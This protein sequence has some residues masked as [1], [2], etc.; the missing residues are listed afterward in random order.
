M[1]KKQIIKF[2]YMNIA[3]AILAA[4]VVVIAAAI[5]FYGVITTG[6]KTGFGLYI[7]GKLVESYKMGETVEHV[8]ETDYGKNT[9]I[10]QDGVAY[11]VDCNC[12]D[13]LCEKMGKISRPGEMIVCLPHHLEVKIINSKSGKGQHSGDDTVD[14]V[15][16]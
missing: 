16:Y 10:I 11:L 2:K 14:A 6:N 15:N 12:P 9:L 13:A 8:I 5:F 4:V 7:D 3:D 1:K